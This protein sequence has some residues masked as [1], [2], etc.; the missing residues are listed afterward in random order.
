MESVSLDYLC[1]FLH[2]KNAFF[3]AEQAETK[4]AIDLSQFCDKIPELQAFW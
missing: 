4:C 2:Q 1:F 3:K